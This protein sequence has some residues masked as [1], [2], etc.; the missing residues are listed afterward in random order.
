MLQE[1][2]VRVQPRRMRR[3][4]AGRGGEGGQVQEGIV[5]LVL[6]RRRRRGMVEESGELVGQEGRAQGIRWRWGYLTAQLGCFT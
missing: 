6:R 2:V 1:V 5:A 4:R 3:R